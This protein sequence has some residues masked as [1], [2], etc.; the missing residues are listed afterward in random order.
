MLRRFLEIGIAVRDIKVAGAKFIDI[1]DAKAG[2]VIEDD[3]YGMRVQMFRVGDVDFEL[4][5]PL[6]AKS[7]IARFLCSHGEGFH[8]LAFEVEDVRKSMEVL[9]KHDIR[10]INETP[11]AIEGLQAIF[12]RPEPF[13]SVLIELIEGAPKWVD[14]MPLP[15]L[16]SH[17]SLGGLGA[18]GLL[19]VAVVVVNTQEVGGAFEKLLR[20]GSEVTNQKNPSTG[21]RTYGIGNNRLK[22]VE[23]V[24]RE[25][26]NFDPLATDR[27]GLLYVALRVGDIQTAMSYLKTKDIHFAEDNSAFLCGSDTIFIPPNEFDGIPLLLV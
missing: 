23:K 11:V 24:K 19:E 15:E 8:H 12:L 21:M 27:A 7:V 4:M 20:E 16:V 2:K 9:K 26:A 1:L 10:V 22:L 17:P 3:T 13:G 5:E 14:D 6:H 18:E 25:G